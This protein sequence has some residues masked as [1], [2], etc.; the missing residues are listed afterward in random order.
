MKVE[1]QQESVDWPN[2]ID[3]WQW[4]LFYR[5][6]CVYGRSP[7]CI[8]RF[9][10]KNVSFHPW[11]SVPWKPKWE[12]LRYERGAQC[13]C[14]ECR[15]MYRGTRMLT[16][17]LPFTQYLYGHSA[18]QRSLL[19]SLCSLKAMSHCLWEFHLPEHFMTLSV[20]PISP[21]DETERKNLFLY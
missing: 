10:S 14:T 11:N 12:A 17:V 4:R 19:C 16:Q 15:H 2:W 7:A 20:N 5:R 13:T 18:E 8:H 6:V 9:I 1:R 3:S 21:R